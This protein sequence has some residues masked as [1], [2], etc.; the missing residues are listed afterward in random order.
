MTSITPGIGSDF[1]QIQPV[2]VRRRAAFDDDRHVQLGG[3]FFDGVDQVQIM[4][5]R[6]HWRHENVEASFAGL[7]AESGSNDTGSGLEGFGRT[8]LV[9]FGSLRGTAGDGL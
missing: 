2:I 3:C 4:F 7:N 9:L 5:C 6:R 1:N 8:S